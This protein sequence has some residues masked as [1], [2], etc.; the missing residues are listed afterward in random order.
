MLAR[1]HALAKALKRGIIEIKSLVSE[2]RILFQDVVEKL[3]NACMTVE[4]RPFRAAQAMQNL[5]G[6]SPCGRDLLQQRA[7]SRIFTRAP[8]ASEKLS[9]LQRPR[10]AFMS[11]M[12]A[13]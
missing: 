1:S 10:C 11:A 9:A 13:C 2:L 5:L 8:K 4:E 7:F 6:F 12:T 3:P